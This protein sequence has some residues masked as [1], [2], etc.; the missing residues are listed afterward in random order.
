[1]EIGGVWCVCVCVGEAGCQFPKVA[2]VLPQESIFGC[3]GAIRGSFPYFST[4]VN[5][6][7]ILFLVE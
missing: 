7:L 1:M 2:T 5:M 3:C 6:T 4:P